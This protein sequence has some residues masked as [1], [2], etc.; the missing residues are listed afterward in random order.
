MSRLLMT[1]ESSF[2]AENPDRIV[3]L[4]SFP[5]RTFVNETPR[6]G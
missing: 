4:A 5:A 3:D 1:S 6:A 2:K